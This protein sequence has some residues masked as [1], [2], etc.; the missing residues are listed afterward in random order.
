MHLG[1]LELLV[2]RW[3]LH[4]L[5]LLL[6]PLEPLELLVHLLVLLHLE[7]LVHLLEI[8]ETLELL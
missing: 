2:H 6:N 3:V 5:E 8:P 7:T 4:Y 1:L